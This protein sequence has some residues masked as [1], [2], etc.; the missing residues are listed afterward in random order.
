[1]I[2]GVKL[3]SGFSLT[4]AMAS[5][6]AFWNAIKPCTPSPPCS[7]KGLFPGRLAKLTA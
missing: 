5:P 2:C 1:M 4:H 3:L 6:S 7:V